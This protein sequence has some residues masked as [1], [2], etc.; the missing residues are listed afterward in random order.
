MCGR[1]AGAVGVTQPFGFLTALSS[2]R[3]DALWSW[4]S[5]GWEHL[6]SGD[7]LLSSF[8]PLRV[9]SPKLLSSIISSLPLPSSS[10]LITN[11]TAPFNQLSQTPLDS[12]KQ[13]L[14][15]PALFSSPAINAI[16]S[17]HSLR[18]CTCSNNC[19]PFRFCFLFFLF[20]IAL[21]EKMQGAKTP[22]LPWNWVKLEI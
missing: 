8:Q 2:L 20:C 5:D 11:T 4:E 13:P 16:W 17:K 15:Q 7:C 3:V 21:T 6:E 1:E 12:A 9:L 14:T 10:P 19:F 18:Y 22:L